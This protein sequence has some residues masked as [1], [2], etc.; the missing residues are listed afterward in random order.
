M[1]K[2][3]SKWVPRLLTVDHKQKC[4]DDSEQCLV[5][6]KCNRHRYVTMDETWIYQLNSELK[7]S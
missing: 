3:C 2:R 7:R 4:A 1:R 5:I 6:F